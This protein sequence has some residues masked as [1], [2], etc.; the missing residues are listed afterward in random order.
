MSCN[1]NA[2]QIGQNVP[3]GCPDLYVPC[4]YNLIYYID[5]IIN[6]EQVCYNAPGAAACDTARHLE[7]ESN[8]VQEPEVTAV[9]TAVVEQPSNSAGGKLRGSKTTVQP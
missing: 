1:G 7:E 2:C 6:E 3:A 4:N 8:V 5:P 9:A